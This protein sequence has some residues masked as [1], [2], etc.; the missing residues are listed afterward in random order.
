MSNGCDSV[1][2]PF[3]GAPSG[4]WPP[5]RARDELGGGLLPRAGRQA[6]GAR[7]AVIFHGR[8]RLMRA[9]LLP[10]RLK[11]QSLSCISLLRGCSRM[12]FARFLPIIISADFASRR[13]GGPGCSA[14]TGCIGLLSALLQR[15]DPDPRPPSRALCRRQL[16][17]SP[18]TS[19][20][21]LRASL[22][23][24]SAR[25]PAL[26]RWHSLTTRVASTLIVSTSMRR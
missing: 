6:R 7:C 5:T 17:R 9:E 25:T 26:I 16:D 21:F 3:G 23:A 24:A 12:S 20:A 8:F 13:V 1:L 14:Q 10:P 15:D 18:S 2:R 19:F 22:R 11:F 4:R